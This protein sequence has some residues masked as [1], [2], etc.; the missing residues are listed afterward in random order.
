M[1]VTTVP[2][3]SSPVAVFA[4][5]DTIA[6][7]TTPLDVTVLGIAPVEVILITSLL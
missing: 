5:R 1:I 7:A 6:A 4:L 2:A 3:C